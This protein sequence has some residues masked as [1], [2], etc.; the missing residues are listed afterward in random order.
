MIGIGR[1]RCSLLAG[2]RRR[3]GEATL[4]SE[5]GLGLGVQV[6]GCDYFV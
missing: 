4:L 1:C 6:W 5:S 2:R 3:G